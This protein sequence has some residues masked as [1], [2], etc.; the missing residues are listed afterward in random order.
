MTLKA[1]IIVRFRGLKESRIAISILDFLSPLKQTIICSFLVSLVFIN[2]ISPMFIKHLLMCPTLYFF[3][4]CFI[5]QT[6]AEFGLFF[7]GDV[8]FKTRV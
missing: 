8:V 1:R 5:W 2:G 7:W 4:A 3:Y 6:Y